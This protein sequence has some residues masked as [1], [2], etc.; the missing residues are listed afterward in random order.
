CVLSADNSWEYTFRELP[1][2]QEYTVKEESSFTGYI[3]RYTEASDGAYVKNNIKEV[4][5]DI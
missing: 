2:G 1:K 3:V 4:F 5:A